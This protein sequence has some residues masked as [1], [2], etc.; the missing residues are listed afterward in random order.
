MI[1]M[2]L[3]GRGDRSRRSL[4][5]PSKAARKRCKF[6][7][8]PADTAAKFQVSSHSIADAKKVRDK[9]I[10]ELVKRVENGEIAVPQPAD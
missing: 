2:G 10:P 5:P 1:R 3:I 6:A 9:G 4:K 8:F 7:G